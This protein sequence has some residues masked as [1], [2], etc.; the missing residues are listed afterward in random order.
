MFTIQRLSINKGHT[1]SMLK[2]I[3]HRQD[4]SVVGN[5]ALGKDVRRLD[6]ALE[7]SQSFN[8]DIQLFG[9]QSFFDWYDQLWQD[10]QNL[11]FT[12]A[13]KGTETFIGQKFV[14]VID[15]S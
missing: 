9:I 15:L 4:L 8:Y 3:H 14:W 13:N 11:V 1:V 5:E 2:Q 12:L 6:K 7:M 10:R